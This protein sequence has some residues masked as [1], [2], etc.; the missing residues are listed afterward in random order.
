MA[1]FFVCVLLHFFSLFLLVKSATVPN[2]RRGD[3]GHRWFSQWLGTRS[4]RSFYLTQCWRMASCTTRNE[5]KHKK[6]LNINE[7]TSYMN[8]LKIL[9]RYL[10]LDIIIHASAPQL[11]CHCDVI[12]NRLGHHQQNVKRAIETEGQCMK[13]TVFIVSLGFVMSSNK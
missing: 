13:I 4:A 5:N 12:S 7:N 8:Y 1:F 6:H 10:T 2:V 11:S 9:S 3:L